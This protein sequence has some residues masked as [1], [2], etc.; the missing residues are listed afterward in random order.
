MNTCLPRAGM[1][2]DNAYDPGEQLQQ[3]SVCRLDGCMAF[4]DMNESFKI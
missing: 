4:A 3:N 2:W 1:N